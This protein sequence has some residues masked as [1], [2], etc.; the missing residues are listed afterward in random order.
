MH[1][2]R[3]RNCQESQVKANRTIKCSDVEKSYDVCRFATLDLARIGDDYLV[4]GSVSVVDIINSTTGK[5]V[6]VFETK[7]DKIRSLSLLV[8]RGPLLYLLAEEERQGAR[9][10]AIILIEL[11]Q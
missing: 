11:M 8:A 4:A 2:N 7:K 3:C 10:A 6:H 5:I 1:N 9:T